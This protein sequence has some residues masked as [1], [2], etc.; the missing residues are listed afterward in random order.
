M[1]DS[2][3]RSSAIKTRIPRLGLTEYWYPGVLARKVG[4]RPVGARMLGADLVF[5]RAG[6]GRV[7]AASNTCPHRGGSLMHGECHYRGTI[8]C[9]Y[10]GWVFDEHGEC[11]Q[12]MP[13]CPSPAFA[14]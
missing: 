12:R 14:G 6:D 2:Q 11:L 9:P 10:H 7:V 8:A 3:S 1:S 5:F 4:R 13:A